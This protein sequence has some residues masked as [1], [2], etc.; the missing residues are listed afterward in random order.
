MTADIVGLYPTITYEVGLN[1]LRVTLDSREHK[2]LNTEDL[3]KMAEFVL[4]N[5]FFQFHEK[6]SQQISETATDNK[7]APTNTCVFKDNMETE[8]LI[9]Q[10]NPT[11]IWYCYINVFFIWT[12][13]EERKTLILKL[14]THASS[15]DSVNFFE[16]DS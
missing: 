16:F 1:V 12:H 6:V 5:K 7:F 13:G 15:K 4:K 9:T 10:R 8:L 2:P 14:L 3:I 11:L